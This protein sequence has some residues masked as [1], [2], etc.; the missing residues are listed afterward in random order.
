MVATNADCSNLTVGTISSSRGSMSVISSGNSECSLSAV[1][2][3]GKLGI[4]CCSL[5]MFSSC[6]RTSAGT[7]ESYLQFLAT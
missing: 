7:P 2:N 4:G 3:S 6:T 5:Y 1:L